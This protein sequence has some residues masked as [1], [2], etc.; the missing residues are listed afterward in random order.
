MAEE[1]RFTRARRAM[2]SNRAYQDTGSTKPSRPPGQPSSGPHIGYGGNQVNIG[3][4]TEPNIV[5]VGYG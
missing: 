1:D 3:T 5:N 2:T 4:Q